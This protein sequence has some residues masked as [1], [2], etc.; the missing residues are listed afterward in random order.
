MTLYNKE[1]QSSGERKKGDLSG[2]YSLWK[3]SALPV[4]TGT[5]WTLDTALLFPSSSER[6]T[7]IQFF[8]FPT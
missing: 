8:C 6:E 2:K 3:I 4:S 1:K 5:F 7:E